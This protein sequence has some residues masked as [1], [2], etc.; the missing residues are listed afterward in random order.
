MIALGSIYLLKYAKLE[1]IRK[2]VLSYGKLGDLVYVLCWIILPVFL[3]P[4]PILAMAGGII[5]GLVKGSILTMV[6][7]LINTAIM[8]F[9]SR[10]I[11]KDLVEKLV[12]SKIT[13]NLRKKLMTDNQKSLGL[14]FF[15]L[16]IMPIVSFNLE[17]YLAGLTNIK[18]SIHLIETFFGIIPGTIIFLNVGDKIFD[19]KSPSFILSVIFLIL[20]IVIPIFFTRKYFGDISGKGNDNNSNL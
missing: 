15:I 19:P 4:V 18:L 14:L 6:G 11:A 12:L 16:R 20:L 2:L 8:Y 5:F 17:N 3:F 13:G 9:I 1:Y 10:Y 7:A